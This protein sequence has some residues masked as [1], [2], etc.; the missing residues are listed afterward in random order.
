MNP[1]FTQAPLGLIVTSLTNPRK[2]FDPAR[3]DELTASIKASGVHQPV[4]LRPLPASRLAGTAGM[5]PRPEYELVAGERRY[6]ASK[7]AG[8]QAIPAMVRELTDDQVLEIQIVE[9]LQRDDLS[10]LE[11]A[12]GYEAL[13]QHSNLNADQVGAKIGKSRSY[14]YGRIKLLDL[15]Q[16]ARTSL[17]DGTVDASR[18]LVVARIPDHKLQIKAM[19]AI[20]QGEGYGADR[21]PMT[22]RQALNHVQR[23]YML[24]LSDAK[25]KINCVDLVPD[26]GGC[27]SCAKRTGHDPDLF[28][29]VKGADI[30][31]DPPCFHKKTEAHTAAL[32]AEAKAKGHTVIAGR[33]AAELRGD[34]YTDKFKGYR[35]LDNA[36]DSPT[37]Q[38][39][40]KII[41]KLMQSE[42]ITPTMIAHPRKEGELVACL[43]NEV[44][45]KLLKMA[46]AQSKDSPKVSKE[47]QKLV[48]DKKAR[49]EEKAKEKFEQG[50]RDLLVKDTWV[51][52]RDDASAPTF[53]VDVHRYLVVR[54]ARSLSTD[55]A[56]ALCKILDLGKVSPIS[57]LV[58]YAEET[59][60]PDLLHVL[61]IMQES[62]GAGAHSYNGMANEGLMLI[63]RNVWGT[64]LDELIQGIKL[65]VKAQVWPEKPQKAPTPT[66]PAAQAKG[67]GGEGKKTEKAALRAP[68]PKLGAKDAMQG[69]AA[70]MQSEETR[71]DCAPGSYLGADAQGNDVGPASRPDGAADAV[72]VEHAAAD[73]NT[74]PGVQAGAPIAAPAPHQAQVV[75]QA[76]RATVKG[77]KTAKPAANVK[78]SDALLE[79]A[80][81][82][83]TTQQAVSV[84]QIKTELGVGTARAM[85]II[86][87]LE[88]DG[89][90]SATDERGAR[91]VL[92]EA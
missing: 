85:K 26:A 67:G 82:L 9:N 48:D 53:T 56:E 33:E 46:E 83:V 47:V 49:A 8:L 57:A 44:A 88:R 16:E 81:E 79:D 11:E 35:R 12:E 6:R 50:W 51:A 75:N 64:A 52:L 23:N 59:D 84:R 14:V 80:V 69:I 62:S 13:M 89:V 39:L 21:E 1:T 38:P 3:L 55:N 30:C 7:A 90:V 91:K 15:C 76:P 66:A 34:G 19:N 86:D 92:V 65:D 70:A 87:E 25:F 24:K 54:A 4:L 60:N 71:G 61:I 43:P 37:D 40:R 17:R 63:A 77:A 18:A 73:E 42:G 20:V 10:E 29:D 72:A 41:G 28:S 78:R 74:G 2:T 36:E 45:L 58:D 5:K 27:M 32:V 31:T 68:K 22:Y